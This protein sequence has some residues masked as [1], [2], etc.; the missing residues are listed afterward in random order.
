M[1]YL[2]ALLGF[3][4]LFIGG[5]WYVRSLIK[6]AGLFHVS[7]SV[8]GAVLGGFGTS[9]PELLVSIS[10]AMKHQTGLVLGNVVG[11]NITNILLIMGLSSLVATLIFNKKSMMFDTVFLFFITLFFLLLSFIN[12]LNFVTGIILLIL[13][14]GYLYW[15]FKKPVHENSVETIMKID[16]QHWRKQFFISAILF[17]L[18]LGL[19]I[20]GAELIVN[21]AIKIAAIWHIPP[22]VVG[23]TLVAV[24]TSLPEIATSVM[25]AIKGHAE[26]AIANIFG[27]NIFNMLGVIGVSALISPLQ[28]SWRIVAIDNIVMMFST[29]V[30]CGLIFRGKSVTW[31]SGLLLLL[32]Y[33]VYLYIIWVTRAL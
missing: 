2:F 33:S 18:G 9:M 29:L 10:A 6:Y 27:S 22:A 13:L 5:A 4:C 3:L 7:T 30:L 11:S 31:R 23:L 8:T 28:P 17:I 21:N 19:L 20:V 14:L 1:V 25:A 26:I 24:G 12:Q 32:A 16:D 15:S